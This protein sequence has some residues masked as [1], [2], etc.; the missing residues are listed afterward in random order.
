[1]LLLVNFEI[2]VHHKVIKI[3]HDVSGEF[4]VGLT[5]VLLLV[6]LVL[7]KV[8]S[9]YVLKQFLFLDAVL[10]LNDD[11]LASVVSVVHQVALE[12]VEQTWYLRC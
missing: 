1:M 9:S 11:W 2:F 7:W 10:L 6:V 8:S 3:T 4:R 12:V 5:D